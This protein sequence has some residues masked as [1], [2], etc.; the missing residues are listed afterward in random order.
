QLVLQQK[1]I[2]AMVIKTW[3]GNYK[4]FRAPSGGR[5]T[6]GDR[7][8]VK[9]KAMFVDQLN[10]VPLPPKPANLSEDATRMWQLMTLA[11]AEIQRMRLAVV[12][13]TPAI[14][15]DEKKIIAAVKVMFN[16]SAGLHRVDQIAG[17]SG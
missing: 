3:M 7:D 12:Q 6:A 17:G 11:Q 8:I 10:G 2:N 15:V 16:A 5:D 9:L 14:A 4:D 1:G 13:T